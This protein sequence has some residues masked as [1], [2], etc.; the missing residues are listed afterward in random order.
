MSC[1]P[2]VSCHTADID[3]FYETE[4]LFMEL[5][6]FGKKAMKTFYNQYTTFFE[7][8][9]IESIFKTVKS[10]GQC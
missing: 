8:I 1:F 6:S 3:P 7:W 4:L 10:L 9:N 2:F 5:C